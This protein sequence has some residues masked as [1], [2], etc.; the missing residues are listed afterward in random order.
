MALPSEGVGG[1]GEMNE[2][3]LIVDDEPEVLRLVSRVLSEAD[4]GYTVAT[5]RSTEQARRYLDK[6]E[7]DLLILDVQLPKEDGISFLRQVREVKPALPTMLI[8]GHPDVGAVVDS[9]RLNVRQFICKPFTVRALLDAVE[10]S[11]RA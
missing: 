1:R 5:A 6:Q 10:A 9:I 8:S 11:L 3:I 4:Q 7:F 2:R